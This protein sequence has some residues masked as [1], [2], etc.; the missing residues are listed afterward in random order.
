MRLVVYPDPFH[1]DQDGCIKALDDAA[2]TEEMG[3]L[4][5]AFASKCPQ[6]ARE[7][8]EV[9]FQHNT[10][11]LDSRQI[12]NF[13]RL[14]MSIPAGYNH[15]IFGPAQWIGKLLVVVHQPPVKFSVD[16]GNFVSN[17]QLLLYFP[18]LRELEI[19]IHYRDPSEMEFDPYDKLRD[20]AGVGTQLRRR[21]GNISL[22]ILKYI[23]HIDL[24]T[25]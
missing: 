7:A 25:R 5:S 1:V 18:K 11:T 20:I 9:F 6:V 4:G 22:F 2:L 17:L 15:E 13:L 10:F 23:G 3:L 8:L 19:R 24:P 21:L 16:F 12:P 14:A